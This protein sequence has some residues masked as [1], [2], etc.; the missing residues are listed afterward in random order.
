MESSDLFGR[1]RHTVHT[2]EIPIIL[3]SWNLSLG[4]VVE[5]GQP[6]A[7]APTRVVSGGLIIS[8]WV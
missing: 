3:I 1:A 8:R 4:R 5:S 7:I 6:L 2:R